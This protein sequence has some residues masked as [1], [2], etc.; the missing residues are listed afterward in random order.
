[1]RHGRRH[2]WLACSRN[3]EDANKLGAPWKWRLAN[4]THKQ[5]LYSK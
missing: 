5:S 2:S 4:A 1:M 3:G